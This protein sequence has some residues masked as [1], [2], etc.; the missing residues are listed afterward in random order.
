VDQ[1]CAH[2]AG[3]EIQGEIARSYD[4]SRWTISW[5]IKYHILGQITLTKLRLF[6]S[7]KGKPYQPALPIAFMHVPK[8]SGTSLTSALVKAIEPHSTVGRL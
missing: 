6:P 7:F 3:K 4:V 2:G 1:Y 5:L 8:T